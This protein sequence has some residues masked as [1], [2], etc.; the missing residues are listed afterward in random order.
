M[1]PC[2][3]QVQ[4]GKLKSSLLYLTYNQCPVDNMADSCGKKTVRRRSPDPFRIGNRNLCSSKLACYVVENFK[5]CFD[6]LCVLHVLVYVLH[7][8]K[9]PWRSSRSVPFETSP[10]ILATTMLSIHIHVN[11]ISPTTRH[12]VN[13]ANVRL[14]AAW[15]CRAGQSSSEHRKEKDARRES[16][17]QDKQHEGRIMKKRS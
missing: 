15:I 6:L 13:Y 12:A 16:T 11:S 5:N 9:K 8:G 2:V 7:V 1:L 10:V 4:F 3:I 14:T 17:F